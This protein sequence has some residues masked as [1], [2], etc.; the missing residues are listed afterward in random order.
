MISEDDGGVGGYCAGRRDLVLRQGRLAHASG[1]GHIGA[2]HR[3]HLATEQQARAGEGISS[4]PGSS[5][6]T[7]GV[8]HP[9]AHR[10]R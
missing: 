6:D 2:D 4:G 10:L 3:H 5:P 8:H 1:S 7:A 9:G